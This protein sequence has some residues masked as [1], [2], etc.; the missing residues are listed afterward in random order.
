MGGSTGKLLSCFARGLRPRCGGDWWWTTSLHRAC[1]T[2]Q[3]FAVASPTFLVVVPQGCDGDAVLDLWC[4]T[5][6][7]ALRSMA[8]FC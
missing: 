3:W 2:Q 8:F 5:G 7:V 1:L 6:S 4:G